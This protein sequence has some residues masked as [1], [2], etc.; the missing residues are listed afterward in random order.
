MRRN[1]RIGLQNVLKGA[2]LVAYWLAFLQV[3]LWHKF[4]LFA[5]RGS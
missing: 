1:G 5:E 2:F 4:N 3:F